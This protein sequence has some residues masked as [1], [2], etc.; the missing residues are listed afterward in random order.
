M[1]NFITIKLNTAV[2]FA[3][4]GILYIFPPS[5]IVVASYSS[6]LLA[7]WRLFPKNQLCYYKICAVIIQAATLCFYAIGFIK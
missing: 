2:F 4:M 5:S 7:N 3:T 1:K 6:Y